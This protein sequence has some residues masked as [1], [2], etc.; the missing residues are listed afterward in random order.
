[1]DPA[2]GGP[3]QGIRNTIP[4][5]K[6]HGI[7][8]E[9]VCL[10]SPDSD[11]LG[12]DDFKITA[13]GPAANPWRYSPKLIPFLIEN[14][15]KYDAIIAHGM[16]LFPDYAVSQAMRKLKRSTANS[17][18][19]PGWFIMPHGMLDPYFQKSPDRRLK[20]F[21]NAI[22]WKLIEHRVVASAGGLLFTCEEEKRLASQPFRPYRPAKEINVGYGI[23]PPP[24]ASTTLSD[25]F[26]SDYPDLREKPFILFLSRIHPKKG[27]DLLIDAYESLSE[28]FTDSDFPSLVIAGPGVDS[29]FG[30]LCQKKANESEFLQK[31]VIFTGMLTGDRKWGAFHECSA[32]VL[33]SHQ[34][35]FGIA[36]AE[37]LACG[38]PVLISDK[39]NIWREIQD[40]GGGIVRADDLE[41]IRDLLDIWLKLDSSK[42][43]N[44]SRLA[45][46]VYR[47]HFEIDHAIT[48]LIEVVKN[49]DY[50]GHL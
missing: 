9:V 34:E 19:L 25:A 26:Y 43:V 42:R 14:A 41:G 35:N 12:R 21:R 27:L 13:L 7:T 20:A 5:M 3:C 48:R 16:W 46:D 18:N 30:K 17:E 44:M 32:F 31:R 39:V 4:A 22:Y 2:S 40:G 28:K 45:R 11:W 8:N 37:A 15:S 1:M 10:D 29:P 6:N 33:P 24:A 49:P 47:N 50:K 38:K 36:V 23:Q